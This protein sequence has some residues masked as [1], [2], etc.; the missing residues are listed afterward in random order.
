M[1]DADE[2]VFIPPTVSLPSLKPWEQHIWKTPDLTVEE[3]ESAILLVRLK[4]GDL[5][6]DTGALLRLYHAIGKAVKGRMRP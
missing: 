4:R 3:R 1:S 2:P 5:N 6:D